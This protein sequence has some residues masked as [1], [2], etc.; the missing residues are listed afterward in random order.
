[1]KKMFFHLEPHRMVLLH[2]QAHPCCCR[3]V[4]L[5]ARGGADHE[6]VM[7]ITKQQG[8]HRHFDS[9]TEDC[10]NGHDWCQGHCKPNQLKP[11]RVP[12]QSGLIRNGFCIVTGN[13]PVFYSYRTAVR[14]GKAIDVPLQC[15]I[16]TVWLYRL[17]LFYAS[18]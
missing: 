11:I 15:S 9:H 6:W 8:A 10:T 18:V 4:D 12:L 17:C 14:K 16:L 13:Q 1:M 5:M 3:H 2:Y 7:Q